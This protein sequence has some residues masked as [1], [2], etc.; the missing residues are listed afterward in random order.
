MLK[1]EGQRNVERLRNREAWEQ[2]RALAY[3]VAL[4]SGNL[5][6]GATEKMVMPLPWDENKKGSR[7][8][9]LTGEER[10]AAAKELIETRQKHL[11]EF[12]NKRRN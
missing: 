5:K 9:H 1:I 11:Q 6:K 10:R 7:I 2:T 12:L 3:V 8:A 4:Y